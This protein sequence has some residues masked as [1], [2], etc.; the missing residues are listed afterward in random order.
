MVRRQV[1][2]DRGRSG[3][4]LG[5]AVRCASRARAGAGAVRDR[6]A[7]HLH[8][9]AGHHAGRSG[10]CTRRHRTGDCG[11]GGGVGRAGGPAARRARGR[12][13]LHRPAPLHRAGAAGRHAGRPRAGASGGGAPRAPRPERPSTGSPPGHRGAEQHVDPVRR[14]ADT[15]A[16]PASRTGHQSRLRARALSH[17]DDRIPPRPTVRRSSRV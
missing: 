7:G 10:Q 5:G 13:G 2:E 6:R 12:P 14:P 15:Q 1:P 4:G 11:G 3:R 17:G 16:V 9:P 8:A